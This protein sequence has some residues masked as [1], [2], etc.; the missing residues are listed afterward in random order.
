MGEGAAQ[1]FSSNQAPPTGGGHV[2]DPRIRCGGP[3][4]ESKL[5]HPQGIL[6]KYHILITFWRFDKIWRVICA[7]AGRPHGGKVGCAPS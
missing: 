3:F 2:W 6:S 7:S 5:C 4:F 1:V